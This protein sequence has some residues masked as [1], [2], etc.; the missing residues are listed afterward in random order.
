MFLNCFS[1]SKASNGYKSG[2]CIAFVAS[3]KVGAG[4][5][6]WPISLLAA[7][8]F[9]PAVRRVAAWIRGSMS[10]WCRGKPNDLVI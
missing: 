6:F 3:I 8:L 9:S 5:T 1:C 7:A 10:E 4:T 2:S